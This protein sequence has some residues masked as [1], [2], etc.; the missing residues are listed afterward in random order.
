MDRAISYALVKAVNSTQKTSSANCG[1]LACPAAR[2]RRLL[3]IPPGPRIVTSRLLGSVRRA[4]SWASSVFRLMRG[5]VGAG[6]FVGEVGV[7][8]GNGEW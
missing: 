1:R 5:V 7:G 4:A 6:R 3:P 2:A 8:E